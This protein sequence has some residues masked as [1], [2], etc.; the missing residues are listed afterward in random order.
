MNKTTMSVPEMQRLLGLGKTTAYWL[1]QQERFK[2]VMINGKIRIMISSFDDWYSMQTKHQK[3]TGEEPGL[4]LRKLSYSIREIA[5][6]FGICTD[7][8]R[9]I[10][11]QY[12][13]PYFMV[14]GR[15]QVI[16]EDF[17]HWYSL[18][19]HYVK[20]QD[21]GISQNEI[22]SIPQVAAWL[23]IHRNSVY[24]FIGTPKNR[25]I[26]QI[27]R[28]GDKNYVTKESFAAWLNAHPKYRAMPWRK[29]RFRLQNPA[30]PAFYTIDE[31]CR[32]YGFKYADIHYRLQTGQIPAIHVGKHWRIRRNEFDEELM[33]REDG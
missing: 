14:H 1:V 6:M 15:F 9:E 25:D 27:I 19:S 16:K 33:E 21:C 18:Q 10:V 13:L 5:A 12:K 26:L 8:A 30:N 2:T 29:R 22:M 3:V 11:K 32:F 24:S 23:G 20:K 17:E 4:K 28:I 7:Q 31:V